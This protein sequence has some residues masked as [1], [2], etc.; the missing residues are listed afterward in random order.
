MVA[1]R[2]FA[3]KR[4]SLTLAFGVLVAAAIGVSCKGFFQNATLSTVTIQPPSPSVQ[5]GSTL[6]LE[7]WGTYSDNSRSQIKSGVVWS[8]SDGTIVSI[9]PNSGVITGQGTGG[10]ATITAAAQGLSATATATA[11]L[12]TVTGFKV[13]QGSFSASTCPNPDFS[14]G[15]NGGTQLLNAQATYNG[16]QVD[17]TTSSTWTPS[18]SAILCDSSASP[19][20]CQVNSNTTPGPYTIVVTYG[21]GYSFTVNVTVTP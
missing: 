4:L 15:Q 17:L 16:S 14:E 21:N 13:C 12:G 3:G 9:D 10:T 2:R 19:A 7:A 20:S 18:S 5:V 8:T 1:G 11:F 6:G